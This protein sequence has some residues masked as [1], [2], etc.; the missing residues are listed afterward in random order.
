MDP[1]LIFP[2]IIFL[3]VVSVVMGL[4][5]VLTGAGRSRQRLQKRLEYLRG[6]EG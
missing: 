5:W 2:L 4:Y 1:S 6:V 3:T